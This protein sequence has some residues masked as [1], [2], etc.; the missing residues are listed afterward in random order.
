MTFFLKKNKK[1]TI[2]TDGSC[3]VSKSV[4]SKK[5]NITKKCFL[6]TF[7]CSKNL[8]IKESNKN[9][10]TSTKDYKFFKKN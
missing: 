7:Y 5:I 1:I 9:I 3:L 10:K 6:N 2:Q 8:K 4:F